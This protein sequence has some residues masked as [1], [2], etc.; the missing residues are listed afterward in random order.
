MSTTKTAPAPRKVGKKFQTYSDLIHMTD[1]TPQDRRRELAIGRGGAKIRPRKFHLNAKQIENLKAKF[2]ET[3]DIV[4]LADAY[5]HGSYHYLVKALLTMGVDESHSKAR[6]FQKMRTLM[7][8]ASTVQ[9]EGKDATT[10]WERFE[11]KEPRGENPLDVDGRLNQNV[12]VMQRI[13]GRTPYAW[14]LRQV[15]Q[16][17]LGKT[18]GVI[19]VLVKESG[20]EFLRL[21]T[22][23]DT[24]V[25][26]SKVRGMGSSAAIKAEKAAQKA[27]KAGTENTD[28]VT[29]PKKPRK[30]KTPKTPKTPKSPKD[31]NQDAPASV[32]AEATEEVVTA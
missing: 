9:G 8:D 15:F 1:S 12:E 14:K 25:N 21:N 26:Q 22:R 32:P 11:A 18:G 23:S 3:K 27:A 2:E 20:T 30:P 24:P 16:E 7:S 10:A 4:I 5:N 31:E 13:T 28:T 19:D 6:V 17:I 29:A